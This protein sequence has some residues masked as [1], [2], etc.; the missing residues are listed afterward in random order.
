MRK[1]DPVLYRK[2]CKD[3]EGSFNPK[4]PDDETHLAALRKLIRYQ[5]SIG[6]RMPR[7]KWQFIYHDKSTWHYLPT[8][9]IYKDEDGGLACTKPNPGFKYDHLVAEGSM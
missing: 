6:W 8:E 7:P 9:E 2:L 1:L 4:N 5:E 3:Y